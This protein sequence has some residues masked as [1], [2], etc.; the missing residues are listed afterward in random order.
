M[1]KIHCCY[2]NRYVG[3]ITGKVLPGTRYI[4]PDYPDCDEEDLPPVTTKQYNDDFLDHF[5][6]VTGMRFK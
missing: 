4:C 6:R 3:K 1:V 5:S 2:C